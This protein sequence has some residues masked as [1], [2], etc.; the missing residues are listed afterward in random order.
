MKDLET[1]HCKQFCT[2]HVADLFFGVDVQ[3]VQEVIR[4]Q[5]M[6]QV[7]LASREIG[8]LINLRGQ[9]VT[10]I[11]L[12]RRLNLPDRPA[13]QRPMNVIVRSD[14]GVASFLVD[15]IGDVLDAQPRL[16]ESAPETLSGVERELV[17]GVYKLKDKLMLVLDTEKAVECVAAE[18]AA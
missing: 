17:T 1:D 18:K 9:I 2:F 4:Y 5:E 8:G 10:A 14:D 7:P 15:R 6:T 13:D 16:Y 3:V 11:N 12:R